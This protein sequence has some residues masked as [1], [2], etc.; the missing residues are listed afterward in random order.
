MKREILVAD[1]DPMMREELADLLE[2]EGYS[3][4]FA[5]DGAETISRLKEG[6]C[7]LLLLDLKMPGYS[8]FDVLAHIR[9]RREAP[10]IIVLTGMPLES[11]LPAGTPE[12]EAERQRKLLRTADA[13]IG[14]PFDV[15]ALLGKI[16][17]L[18]A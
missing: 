15:K 4:S 1:D 14:K 18:T 12:R 9:T 10:K 6:G 13:V 17:E 11:A 8:G 7:A 16:R 2:S 5:E 3:V